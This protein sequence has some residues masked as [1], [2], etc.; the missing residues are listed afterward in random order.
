MHVPVQRLP[1][2]LLAVEA[3]RLQYI[4][5]ATVEALDHAIGTRRLGLDQTV[6]NVQLLT[7]L[8]KHMPAAGFTLTAGKQSIGELRAIVG[9]YLGD[10]DWASLVQCFA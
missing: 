5:N 9:E 3:V 8:V 10:P 7:R 2:V 6:F 1:Q 4:G